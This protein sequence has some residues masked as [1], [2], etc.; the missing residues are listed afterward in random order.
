MTFYIKKIK[1][2]LYVYE[3]VNGE[4][5]YIG[6]LDEIVLNYLA[7]KAQIKVSGRVSKRVLRQLAKYI[8]DNLQRNQE[9]GGW[10]SNPRRPT[11]PGPQPG[12]F[13][14]ARAP[15]RASLMS[16]YRKWF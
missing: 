13:D 4:E 5:K 3:W 8:A 6:P 15:P 12:P 2:K 7:S 1:N 9:C 14:L 10:D 11:P 16:N